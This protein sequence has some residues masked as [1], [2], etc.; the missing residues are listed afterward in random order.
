MKGQE[1]YK[2]DRKKPKLSL[3]EKRLQKRGKK[4][5]AKEAHEVHDVYAAES[6]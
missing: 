1:H 5:K 2:N 6:E 4:E 3:K